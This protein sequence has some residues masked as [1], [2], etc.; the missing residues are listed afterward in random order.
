[1]GRRLDRSIPHHPGVPNE[2]AQHRTNL[3]AGGRRMSC[4]RQRRSLL[5]AHAD[6]HRAPRCRGE[7]RLAT[8]LIRLGDCRR[9]GARVRR[10]RLTVRARV[11]R[12]ALAGRRGGCLTRPTSFGEERSN[13]LTATTERQRRGHR[14][15]SS[16]REHR[17]SR[18][19]DAAQGE[20]PIGDEVEEAC[21]ARDFEITSSWRTVARTRA[22][23]DLWAKMLSSGSTSE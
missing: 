4:L 12:Q 11:R 1:M 14:G 18:G 13:G 19:C 17:R 21:Q 22:W 6:S 3:R 2:P 20:G 8:G 23:D 9:D 16:P 5:G 10:L 7:C 15:R